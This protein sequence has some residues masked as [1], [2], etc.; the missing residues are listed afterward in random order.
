LELE[1]NEV[2]GIWNFVTFSY[3]GATSTVYAG[4][5]GGLSKTKS[6]TATGVTHLTSNSLTY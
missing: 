6:A 5:K 3:N 2:D 1:A 4:L